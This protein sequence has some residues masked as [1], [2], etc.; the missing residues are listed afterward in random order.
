MQTD[1]SSD[2][3]ALTTKVGEMTVEEV[4]VEDTHTLAQPLT[5]LGHVYGHLQ[6]HG[7]HDDSS[8]AATVEQAKVVDIKRDDRSHTVALG[9]KMRGIRFN[10]R[11]GRG[12]GNGNKVKRVLTDD[13]KVEKAER[14]RLVDMVVDFFKTHYDKDNLACWQAISRD[15][16]VKIGA[17]IA[18]C[19]QV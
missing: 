6:S 5:S 17:T 18:E 1:S 14:D 8:D 10:T 3:A 9:K 11:R 15:L 4:R 19:K 7:N 2:M 13:E 12:R 16:G